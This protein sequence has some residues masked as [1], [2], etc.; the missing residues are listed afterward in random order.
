MRILNDT[1]SWTLRSQADFK[2][3]EG[4]RAPSVEA[5]ACILN[6][7]MMSSGVRSQNTS[8]DN[9]D[10]LVEQASII[11]WTSVVYSSNENRA[12]VI[13][14]YHMSIPSGI[15]LD[16]CSTHPAITEIEKNYFSLTRG[17]NLD[18]PLRFQLSDLLNTYNLSHMAWLRLFMSQHVLFFYFL[19]NQCCLNLKGPRWNDFCCL[20]LEFQFRLRKIFLLLIRP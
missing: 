16:R 2:F 1:F 18:L 3:Q 10:Q 7:P 20:A 15:D 17:L 5:P 13:I 8:L 4:I 14:Y 9:S 6:Q 19:F 12:V 11:L